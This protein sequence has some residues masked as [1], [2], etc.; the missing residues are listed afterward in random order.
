MAGKYIHEKSDTPAFSEAAIESA[1][2]IMA[3]IYDEEKYKLENK[4]KFD[5]IDALN[6][7]E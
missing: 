3:S 5:L 7:E 6:E 4:D 1:K 2:R